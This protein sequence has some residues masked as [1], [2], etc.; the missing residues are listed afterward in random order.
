MYAAADG[1]Q[2]KN[3]SNA[4]ENVR[5]GIILSAKNLTQSLAPNSELGKGSAKLGNATCVRKQ[6][7]PKEK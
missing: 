3:C 1:G 4:R 6:T 7:L 2:I 5:S